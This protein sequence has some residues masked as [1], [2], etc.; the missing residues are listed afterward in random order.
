[1]RNL[2]LFISLALLAVGCKKTN[3]S[4]EQ[5][6]TQPQYKTEIKYAQGF[7]I[8]NRDGFK[9]ITLTNPWPGANASFRYVLKDANTALEGEIEVDAVLDVPIDNL[10]VTSTTHIPSLEMLGEAE[11]LIGF[12]NLD[13]ISSEKTRGLIAE[14]KIKELGKNEDLNTEMLID[15]NPDVVVT[16]AVEGSNKTVANIKKMGIPVLYNSDWT[17]THPLGKAEW[18]KFFGALYNKEKEADSIFNEIE[19]NYNQAKALASQ[20]TTRPTVLSGAMFKDIWHLP[21]GDSWAARFIEDAGGEYLWKDSEGTGSISLNLESVLEKGQHAEFWIGPGS[22][23]SFSQLQE[24]HTVYTEFDAFKNQQVYSF[25]T[26]KGETGGVL[27]YE[28]APNRPD[29]VLK[30]IIKILH[31]EVIPDHELY[32]FSLLEE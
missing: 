17:E 2:I 19:Q 22:F 15:M 25:T 20:T 18:I 21:Q 6:T 8:E 7:T 32:F 24:A 9:H 5:E 27:Y 1:M 11:S 23:S 16:F 30:D 29:I 28:L 26:K 12:P 10:V 14:G 3:E 31:P 13:Y 4:A